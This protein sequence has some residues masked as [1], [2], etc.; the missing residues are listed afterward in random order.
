MW[1]ARVR[2]Q[3]LL[4][5]VIH[6]A[7]PL[8]WFLFLFGD[9]KAVWRDSGFSVAILPAKRMAREICKLRLRVVSLILFLQGHR[10]DADTPLGIRF[11]PSKW[12]ITF[13][14]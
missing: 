4:G 1:D 5:N 10:L 7:A 8:W 14:F 3:I 13:L 12:R 6:T 11:S 9:A 2:I